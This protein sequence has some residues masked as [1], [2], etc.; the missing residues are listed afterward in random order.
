MSSIETHSLA[1]RFG[2]LVAVNELTFDVK[3]GEVF[4]FLGPNGAGKTTAIRMLACLISPSGGSA[5]V[6]G[7]DVQREPLKVREVIGV[8]TENP[9]LYERLTAQLQDLQPFLSH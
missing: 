5:T 6:G 3:E 2:S 7:H 1:R 8:L 4:G 9:S